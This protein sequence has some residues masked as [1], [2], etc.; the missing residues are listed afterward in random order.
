MR[1]YT[2]P[3]PKRNEGHGR[4]YH[5]YNII[6]Y[7]RAHRRVVVAPIKRKAISVVGAYTENT[8]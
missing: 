7:R 4:K 3:K 2:V 5:Y 1:A 6:L 8:L